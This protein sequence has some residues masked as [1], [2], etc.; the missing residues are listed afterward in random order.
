M[1]GIWHRLHEKLLREKNRS[2]VVSAILT[3]MTGTMISQIVIFIFQIFINR[4]YTDYEKGLFGIYGTI[5]S[6]VIAVA[7]L[8]FDVTQMLPKS[9]TVAR[10]LKKI[11]LVR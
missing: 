1:R 2:P 6:F 7:A 11:E 9:D 3:L 4:I 8:R 10:V 5:T